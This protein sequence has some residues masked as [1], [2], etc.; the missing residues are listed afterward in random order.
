MVFLFSNRQL[1][2]AHL[3]ASQRYSNGTNPASGYPQGWPFLF[4]TMWSHRHF[5]DNNVKFVMSVGYGH[6]LPMR[7]PE[8]VL[9]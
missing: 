9:G 6:K 7:L 3:T 2:P 1:A 8:T 4:H 5:P